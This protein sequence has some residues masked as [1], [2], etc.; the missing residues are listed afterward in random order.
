MNHYVQLKLVLSHKNIKYNL[1]VLFSVKKLFKTKLIKYFKYFKNLY[2][3]F[4]N[5]ATK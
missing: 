1:A 3:Y 4:L 5:L 2:P